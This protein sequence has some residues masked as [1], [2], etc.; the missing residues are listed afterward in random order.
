M[1]S[2]AVMTLP[3]E[4]KSAAERRKGC[5]MEWLF[6]VGVVLESRVQRLWRRLA[7]REVEAIA[8]G[9]AVAFLDGVVAGTGRLV[10][11]EIVQTE[12]IHGEESVVARVP[13]GG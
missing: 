12:G 9:E 11:L 13:G 7:F 8:Q 3:K 4:T 2:S 6:P 10:R 5:F 1:G